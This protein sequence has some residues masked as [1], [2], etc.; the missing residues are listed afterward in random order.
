MT[1]NATTIQLFAHALWELRLVKEAG[2]RRFIKG[3]ASSDMER[4]RRVCEGLEACREDAASGETMLAEDVRRYEH[5]IAAS[6]KA[7]AAEKVRKFSAVV[8]ET[9]RDPTICLVVLR[10]AYHW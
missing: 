6:N 7:C 2:G 10:L 5:E 8:Q 4:W 1:L 9:E 3:L